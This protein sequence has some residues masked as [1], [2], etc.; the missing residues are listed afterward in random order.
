MPKTLQS[1][2][3]LL[4]YEREQICEEKTNKLW[5]KKAKELINEDFFMRLF[6]YQPIGPKE[7]EYK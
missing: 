7:D 4:K 6:K 5:W 1:I 3:Y 2:F